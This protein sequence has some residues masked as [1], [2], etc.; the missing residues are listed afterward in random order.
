MGYTHIFPKS[1][2][3]AILDT[4][5]PNYKASY[6]AASIDKLNVDVKAHVDIISLNLTYRFDT[7]AP[8][9]KLPGKV[10]K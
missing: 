8:L 4:S 3:V 1:T 7:P 9:S 10:T 5:N 2:K 6:S